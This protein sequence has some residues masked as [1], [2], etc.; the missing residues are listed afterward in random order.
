MMRGVNFLS[1]SCGMRHLR[2]VVLMLIS[3]QQEKGLWTKFFHGI[4]SVVASRR[5]SLF[6][7]GKEPKQKP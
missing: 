7:N 2:N 3:I 5:L 1:R 6:E 4:L